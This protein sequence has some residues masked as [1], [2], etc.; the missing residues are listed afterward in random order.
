[1]KRVLFAGLAALV[2]CIAAAQDAGRYQIILARKPFGAPLAAPEEPQKKPEDSWAKDLRLHSFYN[3]G[4]GWRAGIMDKQN[5]LDYD[6]GVGEELANG[7]RL[8]SVDYPNKKVILQQ[9]P[10]QCALEQSEESGQF[11]MLTAADRRRQ[12]AASE[13]GIKPSRRKLLEKRVMFEKSRL[14]PE[15]K[16]PLFKQGPE[17]ENHLQNY[18]A[19]LI[20]AGGELGPP[21]PIPLSPELDAQLVREGHL[22]PLSEE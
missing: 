4:D 7:I 6:V 17:L 13:D 21:L 5:N 22:P 19:E 20:R 12:G 3:I 15:L 11:K 9:G 8:V 18:N 1:M 10:E 2:A 14:Y 16:E